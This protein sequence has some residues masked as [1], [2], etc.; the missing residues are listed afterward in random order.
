MN[1]GSKLIITYVRFNKIIP[2][3]A[4]HY[5]TPSFLSMTPLYLISCFINGIYFIKKAFS[6]FTIVKIMY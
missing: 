1:K 5:H 3:V 6:Y 2:S 4:I